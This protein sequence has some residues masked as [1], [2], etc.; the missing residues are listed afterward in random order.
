MHMDRSAQ[1]FQE[2]LAGVRSP[3]AERTHARLVTAQVMATE[4]APVAVIARALPGEAVRLAW[5]AI[6]RLRCAARSFTR[7][8]NS[9][10]LGLMVRA[11][12]HLGITHFFADDSGLP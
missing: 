3:A 9:E 12:A 6:D 4:P 8:A 2:A 11:I 7:Y 5:S 1:R 10:C